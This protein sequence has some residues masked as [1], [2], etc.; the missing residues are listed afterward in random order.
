MTAL[1]PVTDDKKRNRGTNRHECAHQGSAQN[2]FTTEQ[3][4]EFLDSVYDIKR[5][6]TLVAFRP[7]VVWSDL[8]TTCIAHFHETS[9]IVQVGAR[10]E[11]RAIP[12]ILRPSQK[13][14]E[15]GDRLIVV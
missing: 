3:C 7:P 6:S 9:G 13:A 11:C 10:S 4:D 2:G 8:G 15:Y 1:Y 12:E 14:S 5:V